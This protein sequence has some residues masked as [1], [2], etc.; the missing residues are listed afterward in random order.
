MREERKRLRKEQQERP[1]FPTSL[2]GAVYQK[3]TCFKKVGGMLQILINFPFV[4]A[5][6]IRR[7]D[8]RVGFSKS[9][10]IVPGGAE[11]AWIGC[12]SNGHVEHY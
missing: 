4:T 9:P 5:I 8:R 12:V 1:A 2:C 6:V 10:K 3:F 11:T 7:G